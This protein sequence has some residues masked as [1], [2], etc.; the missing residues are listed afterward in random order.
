MPCVSSDGRSATSDVEQDREQQRLALPQQRQLAQV[1]RRRGH[2]LGRELVQ[3]VP[4]LVRGAHR[5]PAPDRGV[6]PDELDDRRVL[7]AR[8]LGQRRDDL[9]HGRL[10]A[11]RQHSAR[12]RGSSGLTTLPSRSSTT[13]SPLMKLTIRASIRRRVAVSASVRGSSSS[14][15]L[16][17]PQRPLRRHDV[18]RR[19]GQDR[20][21]E[22]EGRIGGARVAVGLRAPRRHASDRARSPRP[23]SAPVAR[24]A[25]SRTGRR[26][27]RAPGR[28]GGSLK[29]GASHQRS[30]ARAS[31]ASDARR[32]CIQAS[33]RAR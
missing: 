15:R 14:T 12:A 7:A 9:P 1:D 22:R 13:L 17:V 4:D 28:L 25:T 33:P 23:A 19:L 11:G 20:Q 31:P 29:R 21:R 26:A 6:D 24:S 32:S 18:P 30:A 5:Q 16:P 2:A 3:L 10:V 8:L 27:A